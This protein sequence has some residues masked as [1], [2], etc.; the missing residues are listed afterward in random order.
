[1]PGSVWA[2]DGGT[3]MVSRLTL[4]NTGAPG[5]WYPAWVEKKEPGTTISLKGKW[6]WGGKPSTWFAAHPQ[7][8]ASEVKA[9][10]QKNLDF[11]KV[12]GK[13]EE[14]GAGACCPLLPPVCEAEL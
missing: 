10:V 5:Y 13:W 11:P 3:D 12:E 1:M 14:R 6:F 2:E 9:K 8:S 4:R 7:L